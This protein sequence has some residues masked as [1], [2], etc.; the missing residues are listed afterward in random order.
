M[1]ISVPT[2]VTMSTMTAL[3]RSN[4][5]AM[6][7]ACP[8]MR[9]HVKA[10]S[11]IGAPPPANRSRNDLMAMAKA[12]SGR[13]QPTTVTNGLPRR[14]PSRPLAKNPASGRTTISVSSIAAIR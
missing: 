6:S 7:K 4:Q 8:P 12:S 13:P 11:T 2:P 1:W 3:R 14:L 5:N 9:A 10:V